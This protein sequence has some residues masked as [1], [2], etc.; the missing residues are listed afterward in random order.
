MEKPD[1]EKKKR[2]S[3]A[4]SRVRRQR[5]FRDIHDPKLAC[6]H[7][8]I[9]PLLSKSRE[10]LGLAPCWP[11]TLSPDVSLRCASKRFCFSCTYI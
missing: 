10:Q 7:A 2:V 1:K 4:F 6:A 3:C 5:F 11:L 9:N 8:V